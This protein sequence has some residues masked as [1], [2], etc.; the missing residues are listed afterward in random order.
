MNNDAFMFGSDP[1]AQQREDAEKRGTSSF[2]GL[3]ALIGE[4]E[5]YSLIER[6]SRL[7][8]TERQL[9]T[10][11]QLWALTKGAALG[12]IGTTWMLISHVCVSLL[13]ASFGWTQSLRIGILAMLFAGTIYC[14]NDFLLKKLV[15]ADGAAAKLRKLMMLGY[16]GHVFIVKFSM[17]MLP[18]FL[19]LMQV[20]IGR[21]I[22]QKAEWLYPFYL[23]LRMPPGIE[24][25]LFGAVFA[26]YILA[27]IRSTT[28]LGAMRR[29]QVGGRPYDLLTSGS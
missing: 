20:D 9:T 13:A 28:V 10:P 4:L 27:T 12:A 24:W 25:I 21:I 7:P 1:Q 26:G 3:L 18:W 14:M 15:F 19:T 22:Y 2:R 29:I 16:V 23:Q 5:Y 8:I 6:L 17:C 11:T